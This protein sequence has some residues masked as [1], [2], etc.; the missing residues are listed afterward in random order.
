MKFTSKSYEFK[1]WASE[2]ED[3]I[4]SNINDL[5]IDLHDINH[6]SLKEIS[7]IKDKIK[8]FNCCIY[9]SHV[10]LLTQA[11][12]LNFAKSIGM[13][14]YD[15]NNIHS[16]PV[17]SIMPL[18]PE[19]TVNYIPYTNKQLNWHTDG[20]YDE[21]PIFSWLLHCEEPAFSGGE[22]YLLDHELAIREYILKHDNLDQL[23]RPDSFI[24]PSNADAGRNETKGYICDMNNK[25]KKFHMKFSMRQKNIELNE[26][27]KTAFIRM[28]KIIKEDCKK[29][30]ITY[31]LSKNEGIVSN[32]ILHGRNSFVDG[33]VMRKL[34]R[35]RIV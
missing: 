14:T 35:I 4:P 26:R 13:K 9:K 29:Y 5:K 23:T 16:N 2:K 22:N 8:R 10:D 17:S 6:I 19:K 1:Q 34:Y 24:I 31:K 28:K 15:D 11:D 7:I 27:S 12:L 25:Y 32:N 20:Y 33:K 3:N 21:K 18:E 30:C